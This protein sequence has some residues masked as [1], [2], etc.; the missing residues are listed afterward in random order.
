MSQSTHQTPILELRAASFGYTDKPVTDPIDLSIQPGEVSLLLGTNGS[1]KSTLVKGIL[2]LNRRF[3]GDV[4]ING[5]PTIGSSPHQAIGYVPQRHTAGGPIAAT[6]TELVLTGLLKTGTWRFWPSRDER[7]AAAEAID[8]VGLTPHARRNVNDLSGGQQRRALI[9]RALAG[10]PEF[11]I[12]DEPTAGV[13]VTSQ[14]ELVTYLRQLAGI[15]MTMLIISH[16]VAPLMDITS[17]AIVMADGEAVFNG[18]MTQEMLD[19]HN[20]LNDL[21]LAST[22]DHHH[23]PDSRDPSAR[24]TTATHPQMSLDGH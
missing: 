2:G 20:C 6:V 16:E 7:Q 24:S 11:V 18:P 12:M 23:A 17:R 5:E 13:D 14:Q 4:F 21:C 9:A 10:N 1:G 8:A 19:A 22:H 15:G 3:S